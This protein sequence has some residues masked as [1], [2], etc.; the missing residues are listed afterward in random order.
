[1]YIIL[2]SVAGVHV[3]ILAMLNSTTTA[4]QL[5]PDQ[6]TA[7]LPSP[8][9]GKGYPFTPR[10]SFC[11]WSS[12]WWSWFFPFQ[13]HTWE[14]SGSD[15]VNHLSVRA[16]DDQRLAGNK[17]ATKGGI[18]HHGDWAMS[19]ILPVAEPYPGASDVDREFVALGA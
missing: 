19:C 9:K 17:D 13:I 15:L 4:S 2:L 7:G 5:Q 1:M 14:C 11:W 8:L 6:E 12:Q 3:Y 10:I 18:F 16:P